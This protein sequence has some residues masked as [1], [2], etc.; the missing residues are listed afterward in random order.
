MQIENISVSS[1]Q[2][3]VEA[4]SSF[5][6][7][8]K[9]KNLVF[10]FRGEKDYG[11]ETALTPSV[12]RNGYHE[13]EHKFYKEILRFNDNDFEKDKTAIDRLCRMQHFGSPTRMLD[14]SEDCF[15]ALYFALD[16]KKSEQA[17]FVYI[18]SIPES[19]IKYYDSDTVT[20]LANLAK[21]PFYNEAKPGFGNKSKK[22]IVENAANAIS[23]G[24]EVKEYNN[25]LFN[26]FI[27]EIKEDKPYMHSSIEL[28]DIFSV[29]C[30]KTKLNNDRIFAQKGAFF[31]F[32]LNAND[33]GKA[34]PLCNYCKPNYWRDEFNWDGVPIEEILRISIGKELL[35]ENL[36]NLG[37]SKPY[38]Y[39]NMEKIGEHFKKKFEQQKN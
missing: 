15:T 12:Y 3:Y 8:R 19:K 38:I 17:A 7:K 33:A 11:K 9:N 5:I 1:V 36:E 2:E 13:N 30:V 28:G 37:I 14:L 4:V 20:I 22:W 16:N 10:Y 31:L 29:Q 18:F 23:E 25:Y 24:M 27:H 32:G 35:L 26:Y 6:A 39:P 34:I 21:L